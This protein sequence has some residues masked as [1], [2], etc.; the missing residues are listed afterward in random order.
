[1]IAVIDYEAGN[2]FNIGNALTQLGARYSFSSDPDEIRRAGRVI[3]PGVGSAPAAMDSLRNRG[4]IEAIRQVRAPFLGICL[5]LQLLFE[6]SEEEDCPCLGLVPGTVRRFSRE[7]GKVPHV[8]WN[9]VR[10]ADDGSPQSRK[11]ARIFEGIPNLQHFYFVHS[12]HAPLTPETIATTEYQRPFASAVR[13]RN[14][15]GVQFHAERSGQA[16]LRLLRNF[17]ESD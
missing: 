4:L 12:Y 9:Q 11:G 17:L 15:I 16:G 13:S 6:R 2:L 3:L 7:R 1:M 5:G 14:F 10:R 8:G